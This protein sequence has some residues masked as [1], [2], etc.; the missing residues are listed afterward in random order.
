MEYG[1][2]KREL[3]ALLLEEHSR[4]RSEQVAQLIGG[5]ADK[6]EMAWDIFCNGAPPLPQRMAWVIAIVTDAHPALAA[7]YAA[8]FA[9]RIPYMSHPAE[10]RAT[11]RLLERVILPK[12]S[13]GDLLN[14]L[15]PILS[16]PQVP[17]AIRVPAMQILYNISKLEP[18]LKRELALVIEMQ[19]PEC[20]AGFRSR[21]NKLLPKLHAEIR[22][23]EMDEK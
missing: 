7:R 15:F 2:F 19:M 3:E 22:K 4:A 11:L 8:S 1:N 5:D 23:Q 16:D 20:S 18:D 21:A 13:I 10:L 14:H 12:E 9:A 17:V 6:F